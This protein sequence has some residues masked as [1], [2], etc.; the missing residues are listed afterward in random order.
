V[1]GCGRPKFFEQQDGW[2]VEVAAIGPR[3]PPPPPGDIP[4]TLFF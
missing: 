4:G 1:A 2:G 3:P